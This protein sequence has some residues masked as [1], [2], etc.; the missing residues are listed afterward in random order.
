MNRLNHDWR[1]Q[2]LAPGDHKRQHGRDD[3]VQAS[4]REGPQLIALPS[5]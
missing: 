1:A 4:D 2:A 3:A 5:A